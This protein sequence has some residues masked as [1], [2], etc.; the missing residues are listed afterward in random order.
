MTYKFN[1]FSGTLDDV[2]L[3]SPVIAASQTIGLTG[4]NQAIPNFTI[5]ASAPVGKYRLSTSLV[6]DFIAGDGAYT[7]GIGVLYD[8]LTFEGSSPRIP[9]YNGIEGWS[10]APIYSDGDHWSGELVFRVTTVS[11]IILSIRGGFT[12]NGS[13]SSTLGV[14]L[15][16][17]P[18][19]GSLSNVVS[20]YSEVSGNGSVTVDPNQVIF[21]LG[22]E[23]ELTPVN[24]DGTFSAWSGDV[25]TGHETDNPLT[26]I[27]DV[28]RH[29][30]ATFIGG[31]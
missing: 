21:T 4:G 3:T 19:S 12:P 6:F 24:G 26:V 20:L 15:E 16:R 5:L 29:I 8:S 27:M 22:D 13:D 9:F 18:D 2:G 23:A 30:K 1:P 17:L 7:G 28:P 31:D 10:Y 11:D 25:P 14:V